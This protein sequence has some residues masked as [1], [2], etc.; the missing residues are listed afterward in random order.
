MK[1]RSFPSFP[2]SNYTNSLVNPYSPCGN[3][4]N[5]IV[6]DRSHR[7]HRDGMKYCIQIPWIEFK[8]SNQ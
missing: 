1:K 2:R 8:F 3:V 4:L 6:P 5:V 7:S